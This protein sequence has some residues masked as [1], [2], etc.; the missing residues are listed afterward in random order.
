MHQPSALIHQ[1]GIV[2]TVY[3]KYPSLAF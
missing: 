2:S 1:F 3:I